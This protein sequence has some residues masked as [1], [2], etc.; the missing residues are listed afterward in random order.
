MPHAHLLALALLGPLCACTLSEVHVGQRSGPYVEAEG[1]LR[2]YVATGVPERGSLVKLQILK[3]RSPGSILN[4]EIWPLLR[5][6]LGFLGACVGVLALDVGVGAL[7][8]GPVPW[9]VPP[10]E[11]RVELDPP[12]AATPSEPGE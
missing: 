5:T 1:A 2:G 10:P 6:E 9:V 12:P 4:L 11:R 7:L 3:G 8:H